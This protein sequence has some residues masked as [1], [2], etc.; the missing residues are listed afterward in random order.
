MPKI[1]LYYRNDEFFN[2]FGTTC[3]INREDMIDVFPV[4]RH[5]FVEVSL[6]LEGEGTEIINDIK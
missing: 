3:Y 1:P 2:E 4:Y 6:I 5:D